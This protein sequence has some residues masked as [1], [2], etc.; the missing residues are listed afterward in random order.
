MPGR[1]AKSED[2][3]GWAPIGLTGPVLKV[4]LTGGIGSGKS[5]VAARLARLGAVVVDSDRI[6]REVVEP[7]T[8]GL[9]E[10]VAA[11]GARV[12]AEDGTLDRAVLGEIVFA[13]PSA[14]A[15][16]EAI[17]HPGYADA[18]PNWC[19]GRPRTRSWS[20]T[21]RCWSR[22]GSPRRTTWCWWCGPPRRPGCSGWSGTVA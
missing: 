18:A 8:E 4:G 6:A 13:D 17:I 15:R 9:R 1:V 12:C 3:G 11:F 5:V 20:T 7:G 19:T 14:R 10:V 22:W 21:Y 16:L 2:L